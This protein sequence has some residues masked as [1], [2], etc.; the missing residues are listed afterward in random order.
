MKG[1]AWANQDPQRLFFSSLTR[2]VEC[3]LLDMPANLSMVG[4][5]RGSEVVPGEGAIGSAAGLSKRGKDGARSKLFFECTLCGKAF[6]ESGDLTRH[7]R[8]HN[9]D[10]PYACTTC[11]QA[12]SESGTMTRH[13]RTHSGDRPYACITCGQTFR[14]S[15]HL[16]CHMRCHTGDR[17]DACTTCGQAFS[18]SGNLAKHYK[19]LH[20]LLDE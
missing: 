8:T 6:S 18:E 20:A 1:P 14:E 7:E 3:I 4:R 9:G 13:M 11:G 12:F 19:K 5:K 16:T 15:C 17:P 2:N 10:R